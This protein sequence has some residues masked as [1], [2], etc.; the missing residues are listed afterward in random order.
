MQ[1][2]F[3]FGESDFG[4]IEVVECCHN[5]VMHAHP[6][7]HLTFW[8]GGGPAYSNVCNH[9]IAYD[10]H[11][12]IGLNSH[13]S[14]DLCLV[15]PARAAIFLKIYINET[16]IDQLNSRYKSQLS[17]PNGQIVLDKS[18]QDLC[19]NLL[20]TLNR[21]KVNAIDSLDEKV[22]ELVRLTAISN[23]CSDSCHRVNFPVRR[24]F[25]DF[26][27]RRAMSYISQNIESPIPAE[28]VAEQ[29]G[30]SRS[31]LHELFQTELNSSPNVYRNSI[32]VEE[33]L[34]RLSSDTENLTNLSVDL[35]FSSPGNFSRF[36]REHTGIS[37]SQF[38]QHIHA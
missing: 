28:S 22:L 37:P 27:L 17:F 3:L 2:Y 15:D 19:W 26:R 4:R 24:K 5:L 11:H 31:R 32:R 12:A 14:H 16:G 29:V 35:G 20:N 18:M 10:A 7:S 1:E 23:Q 30:L 33:A 36:F 8:L 25:I 21:S 6:Q 9:R 38:R 13:V 34:K